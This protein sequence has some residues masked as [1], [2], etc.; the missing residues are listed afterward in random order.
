[1]I[2]ANMAKVVADQ[3]ERF[4]A[5]NRRQLAGHVTSHPIS[6]LCNPFGVDHRTG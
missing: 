1:M 2:S 3:L 5:L 6:A 4:V